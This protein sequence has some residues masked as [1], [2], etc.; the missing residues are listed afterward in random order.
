VEHKIQEETKN[1]IRGRDREEREERGERVKAKK[2]KKAND[3]L[4]LRRIWRTVCCSPPCICIEKD[5][6][7]EM[8]NEIKEKRKEHQ[9]G[10]AGRK[11][12]RS[13]RRPM[14]DG[15]GACGVGGYKCMFS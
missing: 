12:G 4:S 6:K 13:W 5:E 2:A 3:H 7:K 14:L 8:E 11:E 1:S 9:M 15:W 10:M